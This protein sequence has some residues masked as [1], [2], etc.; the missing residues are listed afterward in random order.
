MG[1]AAEVMSARFCIADN[2]KYD[3]LNLSPQQI[4]SCGKKKGSSG[5]KG[6]GVDSVW[7]YIQ[8]KKGLYREECAPYVGKDSGKGA[9]CSQKALKC[10][11]AKQEKLEVLD[12]CVLT[13]GEKAVKREVYNN[14]PVVAPLFL[15]TEYLT[16]SSG[17]YT[18]TEGSETLFDTEGKAMQHAVVLLG[19][20]KADGTPYWLVR[21]S[22]GKEWGEE[23]YARISMDSDIVREHYVVKATAATEQAKKEAEEAKAEAARRK[24]E[25]KKENAE[26]DAR[27]AEKRKQREAEAAEKR[28]AEGEPEDDP[29]LS[30]GSDAELDDIDIELDDPAETEV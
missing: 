28:A 9:E 2:E 3:S 13:Q 5:C 21:H 19:W 14:G 10:D 26:R 8:E 23:G 20:G 18:P 7:R 15:K 16:Y 12:H 27:I 24:E 22:W 11:A 29:D 25:R 17:V 1:S 6:G 30:E 4:L